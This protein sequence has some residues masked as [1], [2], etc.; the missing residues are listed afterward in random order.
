M[1]NP[2][3]YFNLIKLLNPS[4]YSTPRQV[5]Q[6]RLIYCGPPFGSCCSQ[7]IKHMAR[8]LSSS[9]SCNIKNTVTASWAHINIFSLIQLYVVPPSPTPLISM[10]ICIPWISLYK[11]EKSSDSLECSIPPH[12]SLCVSPVGAF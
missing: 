9:P 10:P 5:E 12:G 4:L 7:I 11:L 1:T 6:V 2:L 8:V 3:S